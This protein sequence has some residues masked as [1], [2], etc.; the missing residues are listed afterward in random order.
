MEYMFWA[1][2][3][4]VVLMCGFVAQL[5]LSLR[6]DLR[7]VKTMIL[8]SNSVLFAMKIRSDI[9]ILDKMKRDMKECVDR[10][11]FEQAAELSD[12][13]KT[14]AENVSK[15]IIEFKETFGDIVDVEIIKQPKKNENN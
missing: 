7:K 1:A 13:V 15:E 2:V 12:L 4:C 6:S 14:H 5:A 10:D 11:D 8:H 9:E 3:S